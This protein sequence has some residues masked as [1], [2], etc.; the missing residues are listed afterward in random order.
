MNDDVFVCAIITYSSW[1]IRWSFLLNVSGKY[2]YFSWRRLYE[3]K[4]GDK[5]WNNEHRL[6]GI[7]TNVSQRMKLCEKKKTNNFNGKYTHIFHIFLPSISRSVDEEDSPKSF[8]VFFLSHPDYIT[9]IDNQGAGGMF[10]FFF[11]NRCR[12]EKMSI[13]YFWTVCN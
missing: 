11:P 8:Y 13:P 12:R 5:W 2:A 9:V 3:E 1:I 6:A 7:E 4:K 10:H